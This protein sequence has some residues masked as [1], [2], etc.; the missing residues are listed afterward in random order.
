MV[1][2]KTNATVLEALPS[3]IERGSQ[4]AN[5]VR[6]KDLCRVRNRVS[7]E[8]LFH[9]A[10]PHR[11]HK[12]SI[13]RACAPSLTARYVINHA[14]FQATWRVLICND[15]AHPLRGDEGKHWPHHDGGQLSRLLLG[16]A[17]A[18]LLV[19]GGMSLTM[20]GKL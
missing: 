17:L 15:P 6:V 18:S 19:S 13:G 4:N 7:V 1:R 3:V 8:I 2:T 12:S 11:E 5:G 10:P 16:N 9:V 20:I 14:L